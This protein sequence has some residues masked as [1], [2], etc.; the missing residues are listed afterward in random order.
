MH[1]KASTMV[2]TTTKNHQRF[3]KSMIPTKVTPILPDK[4]RAKIQQKGST[5][6]SSTHV[7]KSLRH[8]SGHKKSLPVTA[9]ESI[10]K[11]EEELALNLSQEGSNLSE[12][13]QN[14]KYWS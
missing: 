11:E 10:S 5:P 14:E 6:F 8:K 2:P 9:L 12:I 4:I 1:K 7:K 3:T 13:L